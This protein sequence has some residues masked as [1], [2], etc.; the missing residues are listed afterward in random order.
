MPTTPASKPESVTSTV[1]DVAR[2]EAERVVEG[3]VADAEAAAGS[4][5]STCAGEELALRLVVQLRLGVGVDR[6][7]AAGSA[8]SRAT[9]P[10]SRDEALCTSP[11]DRRAA[12]AAEPRVDLRA[13]GRAV[14]ARQRSAPTT[15][16]RARCGRAP[17][18]K[19]V[20]GRERHDRADDGDRG[21]ASRSARERAVVAAC[22]R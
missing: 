10:A 4:S 3:E 12:R 2:A 5:S 15:R 7:D 21:A 13:S 20:G 8:A 22:T 17:A 14:V 6:H 1:N 16:V 9:S 11:A 19:L 18:A